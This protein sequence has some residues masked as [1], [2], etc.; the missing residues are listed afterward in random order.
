MIG[1]VARRTPPGGSDRQP[2]RPGTR[3]HRPHG[4]PPPRRRSQP[5]SRDR[6]WDVDAGRLV[7]GVVVSPSTKQ[8]VSRRGGPSGTARSPPPA[9]AARNRRAWISAARRR[10]TP[11][12]SVT[13]QAPGARSV[14][15]R[16][17]RRPGLSRFSR[18]RPGTT[19][20]GLDPAGP[21][22]DHTGPR[23]NARQRRHRGPIKRR[24]LT[25]LGG[26]DDHGVVVAALDPDHPWSPLGHASRRRPAWHHVVGSII[27][28]EGLTPS[29]G[30]SSGTW[31][32]RS[33]TLKLLD[34]QS[35]A[36]GATG[37]QR[38]LVDLDELVLG[39]AGNSSGDRPACAVDL[40]KMSGGPGLGN[41]SRHGQE[42]WTTMSSNARR[43]AESRV[44]FGLAPSPGQ[45]VRLWVEDDGEGVPEE[46]AVRGLRTVHPT[47]RR[48]APWP[49]TV[50]SGAGHRHRAGPVPRWAGLE[51]S[52]GDAQVGLGS[53]SCF[54]RSDDRSHSSS[55]TPTR[56]TRRSLARTD[57]DLSW[58]GFTSCMKPPG[59]PVPRRPGLTQGDSGV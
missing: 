19:R 39:Q 47:G 56:G 55:Q 21:P 23:R 45:A 41:G 2:P 30:R 37:L 22:I 25:R 32:R 52:G 54:P 10:R 12:R 17:K 36:D 28:G 46:K 53:S 15:R 3:R 50:R 14:G 7:E 20:N 34:A 40:T 1:V 42:F 29:E 9:S 49:W 13:G 27:D 31:R 11:P 44:E 35:A 48:S 6:I 5:R 4:M 24:H 57:M 8:P 33:G 18:L 26:R 43:H 38:R 58:T 59:R 16:S 51:S